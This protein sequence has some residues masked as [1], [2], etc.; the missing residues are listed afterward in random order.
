MTQI[1]P[2]LQISEKGGS[3]TLDGTIAAPILLYARTGAENNRVVPEVDLTGNAELYRKL[4]YVDG[5]I[6]VSQQYLSPFGA[7]PQNLANATDNRYTAQSYRISPYLQGEAGENLR[8]E[9]RNNNIWANANASVATSNRSYTNEV[10][11]NVTREPRPLGWALDY[12]R[13]ETWFESQTPWLTE[14]E[15][16]N[17]LWRPDPQLELSLSGGYERNHFPLLDE[18]GP[19]YGAGFKWRP[20]DRTNLDASYEHRFFG[21][22]YHVSFD[23]HTPLTVWT[24]RA[25]RDITTYPQQLANLPAGSNVPLLLDS[26]F[27]SRIGDPQQRQ[28]VIDQLISDRGIPL[29]L[30]SPLVLF[31]QSV[32]L[33]ES[34]VG[35]AGF[36]GARNV[37]LVT[38]FRSRHEPVVGSEVPVGLLTAQNDNTQTGAQ[39]VWTYKLTALYT[40]TTSG[41]WVRT[42]ANGD[43]ADRS[44]MRGINAV[45]SAPLSPVTTV[46]AGARYPAPHFDVSGQL[47]RD[48]WLRRHHAHLP[49]T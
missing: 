1:K 42:V 7:R 28:S 38:A 9:L 2:R 19:I 25:F 4:F 40:L 45:V 6:H 3:T 43:S 47:S 33:E 44:T 27:R 12:T 35:T 34:I 5:A 23:H 15:R 14:I 21:G 36:I 24:I 16:V 17:G 29:L 8:Y 22:S 46:Y 18:A 11:G 37:V 32:T 49:M 41:N 31:T 13:T 10:I 20:T 48:R 39:A 26:I 30:D